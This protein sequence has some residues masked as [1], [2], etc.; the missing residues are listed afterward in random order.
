MAK[1]VKTKIAT[2]PEQ[3]EQDLIGLAV[4]CAEQQLRSGRASSQVITHYLK[5]ATGK[6]ELELEK[7]KLE[8]QLLEE[9]TKMIKAQQQSEEFYSRVIDAFKSY[10]GDDNE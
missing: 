8:N 3:R 9:K 7:I 4:D 2:T 5:L 6:Q 10:R 1:D